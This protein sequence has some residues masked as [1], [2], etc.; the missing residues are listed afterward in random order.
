MDSPYISIVIVGRNDNY[1]VNF[2][3][4]LKSF[5]NGLDVQV[6]DRNLI[7]LVIVEWNPPEDAKSLID[8]IDRPENYVVR[9]ITVPS[10]VHARHGYRGNLAEYQAKN[11]GVARARG[12]FVLVTNPDIRSGVLSIIEKM[13][14]Q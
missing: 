2:L 10:E 9:V 8:S 7:E 14:E 5:V 6:T 4:R 3:E 11:V 12:K 13:K 1:G